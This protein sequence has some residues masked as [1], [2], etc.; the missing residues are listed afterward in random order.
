MSAFLRDFR[1]GLR[2]LAAQPGISA[3]AVLA[4]GLAIG[5]NTAIFSV[6]KTVLLETLPVREPDTL[7]SF[8]HHNEKRNFNST[9]TPY[10]DVCEWRRDLRSFEA[11][12]AQQQVTAVLSGGE[13]P[14]RVVVSKVNAAFFPMIGVRPS[15]GRN[16]AEEEDRP[17]AGRV[18]LLSHEL[19]TRRFGG[20]WKTAGGAT[21][22]ID[23]QPHA[24]IGVLPP[25]FRFAG[26]QR[27]DLYVPLALAEARGPRPVPV[28]AFARLKR[29]VTPPEVRAELDR[30]TAATIARLPPYKGF[31]L[32]TIP[33]T[34][35]W[36][37]PDVRASLWVLLGAVGLVLLIGCAN[38]ANLLL[39]R[40]AARRREI[41]V[42]A[43]L[44]AGRG[45]L[46]A[47][48]L[49]ESAPMGLA[50]G[51]LGLLLAWWGVR[52]LPLIDV[53]RLPRV[54]EV[55][56]DGTVLAFTAAVSLLTCLLFGLAPALA[57]SGVH[58]HHALKEGGRTGGPGVRGSRL[59]AFLVVIEVALALVLSVGATLMMRTFYS[60]SAVNP[61][62][63]P[64]SL[65]SASLELPRGRFN[66]RD[67]VLAFYDQVLERVRAL[68]GV[69]SAALTSS[70][71]LGGNYF[72][73]SFA[74][75]G[76]QYGGPA[77]YPVIN[78]R[79]VD[80][81][82]FRTLQIPVV[83]GRSFDDVQDRGNAAPVVM[84]NE[85]TA[86]RFFPGQDPI[87]KHVD[88]TMTVIGVIPD[89]KH[90]DVSMGPDTEL[91][92]P[93]FQKPMLAMT[94]VLR[95]DP[96][97][98]TDPLQVAPLLRRAVADVDQNLPLFRV[99]AMERIMADRLGPR[100]LNM[101]LVGLFAA[102]A[103][104]LAALG[105]YGVLSFSVACRVQEIGVRMALGARERDVIGLVVRQMV[106]LGAAGL[107]TGAGAA[108]LLARLA[109]SVLFGV[110]ATDP[111]TLAG[112]AAVLAAVAA[113]A[114]WV[115][116]RR[117][118]RVD[119]VIALRAE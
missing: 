113:A 114:S 86:R 99:G 29:G 56:V 54:A 48:L 76:Q 6:V 10:A 89:I 53:S 95:V 21:L 94:L 57:L 25:R 46:V 50:G 9:G 92:L 64:A 39:S 16:F 5:A 45:R 44:G 51:T 63:Q 23:D 2:Q 84:I 28:T 49:A 73:G 98:Y 111:W 31:R 71:P 116:A 82:Y 74:F 18:A 80:G 12:A 110:S 77:E 19:F 66:T 68:R 40:A 85:T 91:L 32:Q 11:I 102:L 38:V 34:G 75:E 119:P 24:V 52:L 112:A 36:I 81:Q 106:G 33:V 69:Q 20:Q 35:E 115:P 72:R 14:E 108:V 117:A 1:F 118:A 30:V 7:V 17:G 60:L 104:L 100:R 3:V 97:L 13:E 79:T 55:Q 67:Q 47:Q 22:V 58:V 65:L 37:S 103:M 42:R 8:V 87:G 93:F 26:Q 109:R 96:R 62:F 107:A 90:T 105:I 78:L 61:G 83:R 4:L 88:E 15:W 43:A 101:I 27:A 70:L 59:R 41:A